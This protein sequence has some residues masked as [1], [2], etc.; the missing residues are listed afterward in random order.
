MQIIEVTELGVRSAVVRLRRRETP[1]QFVVYP[2]VHM[3]KPGFYAAVTAGLKRADVV[4]V[5]GVGGGRGKGSMLAGA[6]TLSYRILRFNRRAGLVEQD[7][8]YAALG[9]PV[10]CPDVSQEEFAAGWRRVPLGHRLGMWCIF[11]VV[12]A[13]RLLGGTR[14]IWSR[15]MEQNDLPSPQEEAAAEWSPQLEA[16]FGGERDDRLL[17]VLCRLHEERGGEGIEVAVVYGAGHVPSI[18]RG[19]TNRYGYRPRSADWLTVAD[20]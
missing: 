13:G 8:D 4:V 7:I 6:L 3:A 19:L 14:M 15:S 17:A 12:V 16:A 2:M 9:V 1:M 20:L 18:V 10:I 11:P 5:E